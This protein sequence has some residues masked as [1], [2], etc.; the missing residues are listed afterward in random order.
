MTGPN[1]D[2]GVAEKLKEYRR[3]HDEARGGDERARKAS[4]R[5]MVNRYYDLVTDFYEFGWGQSFHF[6]P[7]V[8]GET[9]RESLL[10][11]QH[12]LALRLGL[13]PSM[14]VLDVGCGVGGPMRGIARF[15]GASVV[16]INNNDYQIQRATEHNAEAGLAHL[17]TLVKGDFMAAPLEDASFDAAFAVEATCHAPDKAACFREVHRVLKPGAG[18]AGYEWCLTGAYDPADAEHR[19]LK[20]GVEEGD[21]LPDLAT[22]PEVPEALREAGFEVL[23]IEDRASSSDADHPWY[24]PLEGRGHDVRE[25]RHKPLG[26][27]LTN[28]G[29]G[30]LERLRL[31]PRGSQAVATLLASAA[32]SLVAAGRLGIFTPMLYFEARKPPHPEP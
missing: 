3:V 14:R 25:W 6:A 15:S 4:Y 20:K 24:R 12:F 31:A 7:R 29:V 10:R 8:A 28:K 11:H 19:R 26:Q 27:W 9:F 2:R 13:R 30:V 16:G 1:P 32:K 22:I 17:C 21:G 18:F 5:D 23:H